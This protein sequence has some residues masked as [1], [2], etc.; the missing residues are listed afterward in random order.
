MLGGP[1]RDKTTRDVGRTDGTGTRQ[2]EQ[3]RG[4]C[5][6]KTRQARTR[7]VEASR[8]GRHQ[9][10]QDRRPDRVNGKQESRWYRDRDRQAGARIVQG[11]NQTRCW[12][13]RAGTGP[14]E[15]LGGPGRDKPRG[16]VGRTVQDQAKQES[17]R[18]RDRDKQAGARTVRGQDKTSSR[19]NRAGARPEEMLGGPCRDGTRRDDGRPIQG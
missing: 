3:K 2:G 9:A 7:T 13:D 19:M 5:R 4:A 16:D 18:Y 6:N 1:C 10:K 14:D 8:A 15:M 11:Q 17:R 12:A